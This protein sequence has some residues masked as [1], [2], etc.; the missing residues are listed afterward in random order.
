[1]S[2]IYQSINIRFNTTRKS[3]A[4]TEERNYD[5]KRSLLSPDKCLKWLVID[6]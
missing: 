1:V 5:K 6:E 3:P 2:S 4:D